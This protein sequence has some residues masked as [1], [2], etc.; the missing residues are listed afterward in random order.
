M[1]NTMKKL[2]AIIMAAVLGMSMGI[3]AIAAEYE[4]R[5]G[6]TDYETFVGAVGAANADTTTVGSVVIELLKDIVLGQEVD[7]KRDIT[8]SGGDTDE[9]GVNEGFTITRDDDYTKTLIDVNANG[10]LTLDDGVIIDGGNKWTFDEEQ[11]F[12]DM[13]ACLSEPSNANNPRT[14]TE[15]EE[16]GAKST[17]AMINVDGD[18]VMNDATIQNNWADRGA[19]N[20]GAVFD[21]NASGSVTM[22]EGAEIEHIRSSVF[23]Q[24]AGEVTMNDGVIKD[25][26]GENTN[27]GVMDIRGGE[28]TIN[29]GEITDVSVLG[30]NKNGNGIVAQVY[31]EN[32]KLNINGGHIHDNASFSPGNGWGSVVYLNS[33]GD[34]TMTGGV[35]EDTKS[36]ICTAFVSNQE[37]DIELL[38]G[39]IVIDNNTHGTK[40]ESLFCGDVTIGKDMKIIG[41]E[42]AT[43]LMLGDDKYT[44]NIDGEVSGEG[45]M[46]LMESAPVTGN[47]TV[48]SDVLIKTHSYYKDAQVTLGSANWNCFILVDSVGSKASLTVQP[49]ANVTD[50]MVRVLESVESG[51]YKNADESA[52]AQASAY[53]QKDGAN[54][55]SPVRYYHRLLADQKDNIVITFD[56]NG[57]IDAQGWSG[58]QM[59]GAEAFV[60]ECPIPG[61]EGYEFAGWKY[62]VVNDPETLD[63][64][65]NAVYEDEEIGQTLRLVA[66][67][68][69]IETE[70]E[71]KETDKIIVDLEGDD[72]NEIIDDEPTPLDNNPPAEKLD[73]PSD[74]ETILDEDVP[75]A[76]V[77]GLGDESSNWLMVIVFAAIGFVALNLSE[78]KRA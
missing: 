56:Y 6:E 17:D 67:W 24:V 19:N 13:E 18:L 42:G 2:V 59:T 29:G 20:D 7:I 76:E 50:G 31:D 68:K 34:F 64:N 47:G 61:M 41:K 58:C 46:W 25:V 33:G 21:V 28:V 77:P 72:E 71:E 69:L 70:E 55:T 15:S 37:T 30:L 4:A 23:G 16:G 40:F 74:T 78:K 75:L 45:T 14:Y 54:V 8:I 57:G 44:L 65:G 10:T 35:I 1:A 62:A 26:H 53:I 11:Y 73:V 48:T 38:G 49:G 27:G 63:M 51:D 43:F 39:T 32:S 12:E 66:Q 9:D 60:P 3:Q 22:N 52:T 5:I 36:D